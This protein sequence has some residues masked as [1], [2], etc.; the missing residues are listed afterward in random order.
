MNK[1]I[2]TLDHTPIRERF[3]VKILEE[4][5]TAWTQIKVGIFDKKI[6][7]KEPIYIYRRNYSL[8]DTFE[9][10]RIW[11]ENNEKWRYFALISPDYMGFVIVDLESKN[12]IRPDENYGFC[13]DSFHIPDV[14]DIFEKETINKD[15]LKDMYARMSDPSSIPD[16][17]F[18]GRYIDE[19]LQLRTFGFVSGCLWAEDSWM[20][21]R[22]IDLTEILDGRVSMD[23]RFG[24]LIL[25]GKLENVYD[26]RYYEGEV[27]LILN[28]PF[29]FMMDE[30]GKNIVSAEAMY[31][32]PNSNKT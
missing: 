29:R 3:Y 9:P 27:P 1:K 16:Y 5:T 25:Q 15:K 7:D 8:L 17:V 21:I 26:Y 13:P 28:V 18:W 32:I 23:E 30:T 19:F 10:F 22:A 11:D 14:I 4:D 6:S 31:K 12:I 2:D 20:K 24:Y